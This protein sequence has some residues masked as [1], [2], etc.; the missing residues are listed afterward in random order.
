MPLFPDPYFTIMG[1]ETHVV[2]PCS[3]ENIAGLEEKL[4]NHVRAAGKK[5]C[6]AEEMGPAFGG[7]EDKTTGVL[8]PGDVLFAWKGQNSTVAIDAA[9]ASATASVSCSHTRLPAPWG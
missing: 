4:R 2:P 7:G 1:D 9:Q 6:G 5:F 8:R 3:L